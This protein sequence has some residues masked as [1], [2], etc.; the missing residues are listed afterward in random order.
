[1]ASN[2]TEVTEVLKAI[3][4]GVV[5]HA[6]KHHVSELMLWMLVKAEADRQIA[7]LHHTHDPP[8]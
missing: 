5:A 2:A 8:H 4:S 3:S 1:M 6:S 7:T